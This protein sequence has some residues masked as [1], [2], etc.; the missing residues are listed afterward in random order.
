MAEPL[1]S[2]APYDDM[3]TS[4]L[5][6]QPI[7]APSDAQKASKDWDAMFQHVETRMQSL[8]S[9]RW[10]KWAYWQA[11]AKFFLP[12]RYLWVV[13]ANRF[14]R[15]HPVND[16]IVD[17]T[18]L[19]AVRTCAS[20][21]WTG[22]TSP[23]RPWFGLDIGVPWAELQPDGKAWIEDVQSR[24]YT[25]LKASNFYDQMAQAF[26]DLVVF[27]TAPIIIYEDAEDVIRL[28]TPCAGEYFCDVGARLT[29]DTLYREF[30]YNTMQI[31]DMF[32]L[33]NCPMEVR[34]AWANGGASLQQEF[35]VAHAIEPNTAVAKPGS[36]SQERLNMVPQSFAYR[37]LYWLRGIKAAQ[38]LSAKGFH[39][40]PFMALRWSTVSNDPYGRGPCEDALGD[41]KQIQ[42]ETLRKAEFID[43]GVRPPMGASPELK[44]EPA[45]IIPGQITYFA[46]D[47]GKK[48]FFPLFEPNPAWLPA[49]TNDIETVSK[50]I[51][52]CL[53]VDLFMAIT[54]ME[55][56]QPR[57]ELE[58]SQRNL[59]RLQEL[60]PVIE[61]AEKELDI[62][63]S[64]I[65]NIMTRRKMLPPVPPSLR[66]VPLKIA[67]TSIMRLAQRSSE[68]VAMKDFFQTAGALSSAAKASGVPDPLR[69]V[70]LDKS[71]RHYGDLNEFPGSLFFTDGEIAEHDK[72]REQAA[73]QAK[74]PEQAM[75]GVQAAKT[76]ASTQMGGNTALSAML[77]G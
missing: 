8:R 61:L 47:N 1:E 36:A 41:N 73:A 11:L 65:L 76:L 14:D 13:V 54:R 4:L 35:I 30:V 40:K 64:R 15:G 60:G 27:G 46:T 74:M 55:G 22:L 66:G 59:E 25:V 20:G 23:S 49:L 63:I 28:Y 38:P 26:R 17:S 58:L 37:E 9:W 43:K 10:A 34:T 45:S 42:Q 29:V 77:G 12:F 44:N 57:N 52:R 71:L 6:A 2:V 3:T 48:G 69:T 72:V 24:M 5:A 56:V 21:M 31:V 7:S 18:G 39:G 33:E 53:F 19:L 16:A 50:R 67:Y 51:E 32:K 75:A 68:S 62:A 70:N